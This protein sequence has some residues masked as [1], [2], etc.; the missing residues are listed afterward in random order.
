MLKNVK[1]GFEYLTP[2][3]GVCT[4]LDFLTETILKVENL[5]FF[6]VLR[7]NVESLKKIIVKPRHASFHNESIKETTYY[8]GNT[9]LVINY[10]S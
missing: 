3:Q 5:I 6:Y 7:G 2:L 4:S 8:M 9:T 1:C 10:L